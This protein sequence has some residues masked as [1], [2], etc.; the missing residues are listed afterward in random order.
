MTLDF[1]KDFA[2]AVQV[3]LI[4][5]IHHEA[6]RGE[7]LKLSFLKMRLKWSQPGIELLCWKLFFKYLQALMPDGVRHDGQPPITN[8]APG[9]IHYGP[10]KP[11]FTLLLRAVKRPF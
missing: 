2:D 7:Q 4:H 3:L 11:D 10:V 6:I 1:L 9:D 8:I 5:P